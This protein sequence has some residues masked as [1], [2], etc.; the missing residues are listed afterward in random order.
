VFQDPGEAALARSLGIETVGPKRAP[1][2]PLAG[3]AARLKQHFPQLSDGDA[4]DLAGAWA[5]KMFPEAKAIQW[6]D[7]GLGPHDSATA[8]ALVAQGIK[9]EHLAVRIDGQRIGAVL[10]GGASAARI[11]GLLRRAGAL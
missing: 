3:L 6:W 9:P 10:R 5:N 4:R 8:A 11:A 1:Q 7:A 2:A